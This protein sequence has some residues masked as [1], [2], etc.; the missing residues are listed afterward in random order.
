MHAPAAVYPFTSITF[1]PAGA[2]GC[3]GPTLAQAL[4]YYNSTGLNAWVQLRTFYVVI[5]AGTQV[6]RLR[7]AHE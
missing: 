6:W 2:T 1:T 7:M 5:G 4:D 3:F